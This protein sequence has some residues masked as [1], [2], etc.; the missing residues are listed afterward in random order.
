M[1]SFRELAD[2]LPQV[3]PLVP[4]VEAGVG[5]SRPDLRN[6]QFVEPTLSLREGGLAGSSVVLVAAPAAVGKT[7]FAEALAADRRAAIW[8]LGEFPVGSG[9]FLGKLTETHGIA[10]LADT[11]Q[12]MTSGK[13]C[14]VLDALDE[15]YSRARSDNFEAFVVDLAKQLNGLRPSRPAVVACGRSD[16]VELTRLLLEDAG[17]ACGVV[18]L[19]FFSNDA[20]R[21]FVELQ[22]DSVGHTAHRRFR[23]PFEHARDA[24]FER[25]QEAI[26]AEEGGGGMDPRSF[27]GYAPVL[28]ALGRYL[29][30]GDYQ[31]L[32][33][34]LPAV[35][36]ADADA[37][38]WQ[39]LERIVLDLLVR[40]RPKLVERLPG[41]VRAIIPS[42][43]LD[44]LY[45]PEEQCDRLLSRSSGSSPPVIDL[46]QGAIAG[47]EKS[48]NETLGEH[49]FVGD[50]PEGFASVVFRDYV[51]AYGL[52]GSGDASAARSLAHRR[53]F[54]PS[55]LLLRFF[56]ERIAEGAPIATTDVDILYAS[57]QA[58]E[59]GDARA[60]LRIEQTSKG[61]DIEISTAGGGLVELVADETPERELSLGGRVARA[62]VSAP[63]WAVVIGRPGEEARVGPKVDLTC[64]SVL[65]VASSMRVEARATA[66]L[67]TW[68]AS[69]VDNEAPDF[70]LVGATSDRFRLILADP[71]SYPWSSYV[72]PAN[73][74][75]DDEPALAE[76]VREL[77][78]LATR[79]KP[80]VVAGSNPT[81][82]TKILDVLVA[83][84]RVSPSLYKYAV[85][86]G[87]ITVVG[88]DAF[89]N[90]QQYGINIVDL[91][92]RRLTP[93]LR[94]YLGKYIG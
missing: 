83:R 29:K 65:V 50:G 91:R 86:T 72:A 37:S 21:T 8:D 61:L 81:L 31:E 92:Q 56:I 84:E 35:H 74:K 30:V 2:A 40:E 28:I 27:L 33:Q 88:Q 85:R 57:A 94:T 70:R 62:D 89:L 76:A 7:M 51:I 15:G 75:C 53:D 16:T 46:P 12:R 60:E 66:D 64:A 19:D 13:Y 79:F 39:F 48:V 4:L 34:R 52:A 20:A 3:D 11:T 26:P 59:V 1:V 17:V 71:P 38:L 32:S 36:G 78:K 47:Y 82:P 44:S 41:E 49:A 69:R 9:T 5:I 43:Q 90:P 25:V 42:S 58:E 6:P 55:P 45:S 63:R 10:A 67:V 24:L 93:A 87:L 68:E 80:G 73:G 14:V 23:V 18:T 54:K 22:L 77:K